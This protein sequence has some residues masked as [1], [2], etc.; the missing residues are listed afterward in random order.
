VISELEG[1]SVERW[2]REWDQ[3]TKGRSTKEYFPV[4]AEIKNEN[5]HYPKFRIHG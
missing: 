4:G 3:T 5:K 2:Q 1:I